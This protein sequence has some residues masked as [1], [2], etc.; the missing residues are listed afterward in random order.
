M[1]FHSKNVPVEVVDV[2]NQNIAVIEKWA[3]EGVEESKCV[4]PVEY[5]SG[6]EEVAT[7]KRTIRTRRIHQTVRRKGINQQDVLH[8]LPTKVPFPPFILP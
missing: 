6:V 4:A 2:I 8:H 5:G 7:R 1:R 3:R